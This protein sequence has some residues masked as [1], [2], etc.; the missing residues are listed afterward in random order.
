[1]KNHRKIEYDPFNLC[2]NLTKILRKRNSYRAYG[3]ACTERKSKTGHMQI[4]PE[5]FADTD[6][7]CRFL[8]NRVA[9]YSVI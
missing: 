1:M 5:A 3:F 8:F 4:N 7:N 9:Q 2:K 6:S